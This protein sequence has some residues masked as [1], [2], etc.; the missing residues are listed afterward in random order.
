MSTTLSSGAMS[1]RS[2][3]TC[4]TGARQAQLRQTMGRSV[5]PFLGAAAALFADAP[6]I[7][8]SGKYSVKDAAL[9]GLLR[10]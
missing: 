7:Y 10:N 6:P 1:P 3:M 2:S 9:A 4:S 5:H 8:V